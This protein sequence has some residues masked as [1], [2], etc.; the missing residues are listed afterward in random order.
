MVSTAPEHAEAS[1]SKEFAWAL[2]W[3]AA[4]VALA[5][6]PYLVA[7]LLT[8][9]GHLFSGLLSNPQDG[10]SYLAKMRFAAD[11]AWLFRLPYTAENHQG[12]PLYLFYVLLGKVA[13]ALHLP[14]VFVY[15]LARVLSGLFFLISAHFL[16]VAFLGE[17]SAR[18]LAFLLLAFGS[19]LSWLT[20]LWG[21]VA[22]DLNIP[23]SNTFHTLFG[24]PHF[25][26][27][28]GLF[29]CSFLLFMKGV[30]KN[31]VAHGLA[32][33]A[34]AVG[35]V[36][37]QPFLFLTAALLAAIWGALAVRARAAAAGAFVRSYVLLVLPLLPV[38]AVTY[39]SIYKDPVLAQ[40]TAQ[41]ITL[42]PPPWDYALGYGVL[43]LLAAAAVPSLWRG[44]KTGV[45]GGRFILLW[46][47][48]GFALLYLP[49]NFQRRLSEGL[50]LP[51]SMAA[52]VGLWWLCSKVSQAAR[53]VLLVCGFALS[54]PTTL[55]LPPMAVLGALQLGDP[56]Y[57]GKAEAEAYTW[58]RA[59]SRRDDVVMA[60]PVSGNQLPAWAGVRVVWGHPF[61]TA[62]SQRKRQLVQAL[63]GGLLPPGRS[64]NIL[65]AS[66]ATLL[67][68]G[69]RERSM[70]SLDP[71]LRQVLDPVYRNDY[72]EIF[73][74]NTGDQ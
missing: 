17:T 69:E 11:G 5:T 23:E 60:G 66:G 58:L 30:S 65:T 43:L 63:Y 16:F 74:V 20:G 73:R 54:L 18:R 15:H 37:A 29:I 14:V 38:L 46:L 33:G 24:N 7:L 55:L 22:A 12:A 50:H 45:V 56:F 6:A 61:E 26:F 72:V 2:G 42:S 52:G 36:A 57:I 49:A 41:N 34:L 51:V 1:K 13:G 48:L 19:G 27:S 8:P 10:N 68:Y 64:V 3:S 47:L 28:L 40:W 32:A 62:D 39:V 21:Y 31:S 53:K 59:N 35:A 70:G 67:Y 44:D 25:P 71:E 9:S 4:A